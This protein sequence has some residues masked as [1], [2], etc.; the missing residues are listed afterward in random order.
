MVVNSWVC[1]SRFLVELVWRLVWVEVMMY[2]LGDG[3]EVE[4]RGTKAVGLGD[5]KT[6]TYSDSPRAASSVGQLAAGGGLP[7]FCE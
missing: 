5:Q 3:G 2:D 1:G 6:L 7:S 4:W